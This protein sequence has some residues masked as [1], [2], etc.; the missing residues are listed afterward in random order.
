[1]DMIEARNR[2]CIEW[3]PNNSVVN[4][5]TKHAILGGI[6]LIPGEDF[7]LAMSLP[8]YERLVIFI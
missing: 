8:Q 7:S 3:S 1:M 6:E 4:T 2:G 5:K